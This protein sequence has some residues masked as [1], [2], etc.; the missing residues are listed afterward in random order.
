[1]RKLIKTSLGIIGVCGIVIPT[2]VLTSCK[3]EDNENLFLVSAIFF[4]DGYRILFVANKL[5]Y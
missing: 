1:V 2:S 3:E 4:D 5:C